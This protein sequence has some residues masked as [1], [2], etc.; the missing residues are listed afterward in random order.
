M[1]K[2]KNAVLISTCACLLLV[3]ILIAL[4]FLPFWTFTGKESGEQTM[5]IASYIWFPN[6]VAQN[7]FED[8]VKVEVLEDPAMTDHKVVN[9]IVMLPAI[10]FGLCAA[11]FAVILL[12]RKSAVAPAVITIIAALA[13]LLSYLLN[14]VLKAYTDNWLIHLIVTIVVLLIAVATLVGNT[15][16][17]KKNNA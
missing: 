1:F 13:S 10:A 16:N 17:S 5:S 15:R 14:P 11:A 12:K 3:V 9:E 6:D 8:M 4:Q 7:E 2:G